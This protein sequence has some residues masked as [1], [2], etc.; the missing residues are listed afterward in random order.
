MVSKI[1]GAGL[2]TSQYDM[3]V[4][5]SKG[6]GINKDFKEAKEWYL[7]S[8][9]QNYGYAIYNLGVIYERGYGE[10]SDIKRQRVV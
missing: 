3:G 4:M 5:L 8:A 2:C 10:S 9:K 1:C 6:E 7:K